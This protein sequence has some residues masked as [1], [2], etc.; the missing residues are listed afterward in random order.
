ML[1]IGS[2]SS[3]LVVELKDFGPDGIDN[4]YTSGGDTAGGN[5]IS[6]QLVKDQWVGINIPLNQFT[7]RT[8][9]GGSGNPNKNNLGFII[10]VSSN[11]ASF[12]VD[13]I[14]FY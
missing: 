11:S 10:L 13:N 4:N 12:L 9:G 5:N 14:Y 2:V 6:S 7:L 8:G 1:L 3:N